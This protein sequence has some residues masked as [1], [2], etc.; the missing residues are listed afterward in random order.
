MKTWT[1]ARNKRLEKALGADLA[2]KVLGAL[3]QQGPR[4]GGGGGGK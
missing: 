4:P 1:E 3:P 2:K